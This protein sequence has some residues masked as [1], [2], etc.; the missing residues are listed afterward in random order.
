MFSNSG[1]CF[2]DLFVCLFVCLLQVSYR[3]FAACV[4]F[5][6][7]VVV[8]LFYKF[9]KLSLPLYFCN[10]CWFLEEPFECWKGL[11]VYT[12]DFF[13]VFLGSSTAW[14]F[15]STPP[16]AMTPHLVTDW[17]LHRFEQLAEDAA[18]WYG[19]S[20]CPELRWPRVQVSRLSDTQ[21]RQLHRLERLT[22][23]CYSI[24]SFA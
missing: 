17:V 10:I 7:V 2:I 20:C 13:S 14:M 8:V 1:L 11:L 15:G 18:E 4:C 22:L 16:W 21:G 23:L 24:V 9:N 12:L 3:L 19:F 6:M 5:S